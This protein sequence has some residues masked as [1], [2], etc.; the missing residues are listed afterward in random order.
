MKHISPSQYL[1]FLD[2]EKKFEFMQNSDANSY[3]EPST[4]ALLGIVAHNLLSKVKRDE[5]SIQNIDLVFDQIWEKELVTLINLRV[6]PNKKCIST[7]FKTWPNYFFI[8]AKTKN[9]LKKRIKDKKNVLNKNN[10]DQKLIIGIEKM[11]YDDELNLMG[12]PDFFLVNGDYAKIVDFKSG[13]IDSKTFERIKIQLYLYATLIMSSYA[14]KRVDLVIDQLVGDPISIDFDLNE[15]SNIKTEFA[16]FYKNQYSKTKFEAY[17]SESNCQGCS[18]AG[19][20]TALVESKLGLG[21]LKN[22]L[23]VQGV[24][25]KIIDTGKENLSNI[26]LT[27]IKIVPNLLKDC[28]ELVVKNFPRTKDLLEGERLTLWRN[29]KLDSSES[30]LFNIGSSHIIVKS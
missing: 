25:K 19:L 27:D 12:K 21:N 29:L 14:V 30:I 7:Q 20:C 22:P 2:C 18:F 17:P 23:V 5:F 1:N 8:K 13:K 24:I 28:S 26:Q 11:L 9:A 10:S 3:D 15:L 16:L 6:S 4:A